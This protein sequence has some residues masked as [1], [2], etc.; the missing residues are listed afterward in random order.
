V[1]VF[2]KCDVVHT[3]FY[4]FGCFGNEAF[5]KDLPITSGDSTVRGNMSCDSTYNIR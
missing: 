5:R 1:K 4:G 3:Y 2:S